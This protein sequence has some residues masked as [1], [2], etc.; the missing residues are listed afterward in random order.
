MGGGAVLWDEEYRLRHL[1]TGMYLAVTEMPT[2][3][4][5]SAFYSELVSEDDASAAPRSLF[6]FRAVRSTEPDDRGRV[7]LRASDMVLRL[8]HTTSSGEHLWLHNTGN[9]KTTAS[10]EN[11]T[12]KLLSFSELCLDQDTVQLVIVP[13]DELQDVE[14]CVSAVRL[15]RVFIEQ[16]AACRDEIQRRR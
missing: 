13:P 6:S 4:S 11:K 16:L 2:A 14:I 5:G 8:H 3:S 12:S 7:P 10:G 9:C 1:G 15:C